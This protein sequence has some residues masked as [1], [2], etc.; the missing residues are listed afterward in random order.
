[1]SVRASRR[2]VLWPF[3]LL[4]L[5]VSPINSP[6]ALPLLYLDIYENGLLTRIIDANLFK[7]S[8]IKAQQENEALFNKAS[9]S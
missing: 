6:F 8:F 4:T 7:E 1:M 9:E 5:R 2:L 3:D